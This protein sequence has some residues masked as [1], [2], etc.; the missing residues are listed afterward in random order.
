MKARPLLRS[1]RRILES[2]RSNRS[3]VKILER[4]GL[5]T[6]ATAGAFF[7]LAVGVRAEVLEGSDPW[8]FYVRSC[9]SPRSSSDASRKAASARAEAAVYE[10]FLL[11]EAGE[12]LKLPEGLGRLRSRLAEVAAR[13]FSA[14]TVVGCEVLRLEFLADGR[15][16]CTVKIPKENLKRVSGLD[17][18]NRPES[19]IGFCGKNPALRYEVAAILG[20]E[21]N[22]MLFGGRLGEE[23]SSKTCRKPGSCRKASS[24]WKRCVRLRTRIC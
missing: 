12:N 24:A 18:R 15:A 8:C 1:G 13:S 5:L 10:E 2:T 22:E 17:F 20:K 19:L 9:A 4:F 11:Y 6:A 14:G 21:K 23:E 16:R 7:A 3:K